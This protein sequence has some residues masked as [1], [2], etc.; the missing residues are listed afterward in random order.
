MTGAPHRDGGG[1]TARRHPS[2]RRRGPH[3]GETKPR[4]DGVA[5]N[6][7]GGIRTGGNGPDPG[8]S[9]ILAEAVSA[10]AIQLET[11]RDTKIM[12]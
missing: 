8:P 11:N 2:G 7:R 4:A 9:R 5:R 6:G 1:Q 12:I 3:S 10:Y